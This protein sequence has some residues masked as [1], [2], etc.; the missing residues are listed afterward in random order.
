MGAFWVLNGLSGFP[1]Q[2]W[3]MLGDSRTFLFCF[4]GFLSEAGRI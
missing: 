2:P 1:E 3:C 4:P